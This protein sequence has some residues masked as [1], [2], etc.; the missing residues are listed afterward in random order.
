MYKNLA[1]EGVLDAQFYLANAY[2][3]GE[4]TPIDY[5][6]AYDRYFI[7]AQGGD[8][9]ANV[10]IAIIYYEGYGIAL[11]YDLAAE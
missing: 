5:H 8:A 6:K 4:G 2:E 11:D 10:R 1:E 7:A 3:K 9:E